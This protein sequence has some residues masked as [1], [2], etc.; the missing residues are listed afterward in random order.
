MFRVG[1]WLPL[2]IL[3]IE[4]V[5]F[6]FWNLTVE[7]QVSPIESLLASLVMSSSVLEALPGKL[8]IKRP[9]P[10]ILNIIYTKY[11]HVLYVLE[12]SGCNYELIFLLHNS[13]MLINEKMI[14]TVSLRI[15]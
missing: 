11:A 12:K 5:N 13:P 6:T 14:V 9:S 7:T 2:D 10:S 8:D 4:R 3:N 15:S 1:F